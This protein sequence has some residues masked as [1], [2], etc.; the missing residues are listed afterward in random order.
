MGNKKEKKMHSAG[1]RGKNPVRG[2]KHEGGNGG[3]RKGRRG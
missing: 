1:K 3:D 2:S